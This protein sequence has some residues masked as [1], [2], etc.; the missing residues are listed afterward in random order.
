MTMDNKTQSNGKS[1]LLVVKDLVKYFPVRGGILQRTIAQVQAVDR[2][3]FI[4]ALRWLKED[5][6]V[7]ALHQLVVNPHRPERVEPRVC[8][9]RPKPYPL[10][11]QPRH[12]L[13][14]KIL[15]QSLAA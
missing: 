4:D 6:P 15:R 13:R 14:Q 9:R 10:M 8:K 5:R 2:V 7:I 11:Q 12:Q 3:S 1:D